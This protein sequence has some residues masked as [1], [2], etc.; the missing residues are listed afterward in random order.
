MFELVV[1]DAR[2]HRSFLAVADEFI[3]TGQ[4]RYAGLLSWPADETFPGLE[5]TRAGL[6]DPRAF[7]EYVALVA[8][9]CR[10]E[11]PRPGIYVPFTELWMT[12]GDEYLGRISLRHRLTDVLLTWGGHIGY[13]VRPSARG[14]GYARMA[15]EQM[16]PRCAELRIDPVLVTCDTDNHASRRTI[17]GAGGRYEDTREGK[18]RYWVPTAARARC[19]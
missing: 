16:L 13:A 12:D 11:M 2:Y 10:E 7:A 8:G 4:D 17:E 1:P 18:L 5:V 14:H 15:L 6:E 3:A 9:Q 19:G